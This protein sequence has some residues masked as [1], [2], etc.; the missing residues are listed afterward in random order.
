[1]KLERRYEPERNPGALL[2]VLLFL[3]EREL[4]QKAAAER[5]A[6]EPWSGGVVREDDSGENALASA[7]HLEH[8]YD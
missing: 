4:Q 7:R 1:M 6:A 5:A 2:R 8:P 3:I